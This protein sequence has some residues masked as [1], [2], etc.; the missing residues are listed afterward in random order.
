MSLL[1]YMTIFLKTQAVQL[2]KELQILLAQQGLEVNDNVIEGKKILIA[3]GGH[4]WT[5]D[6]SGVKEHAITSNEALKL[7]KLPKNISILGSGYIAIE[8]AFI[9][10]GFGSN[11]N[12]IQI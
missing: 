8:F 4:P 10:R 3:T 1:E 11:V 2:L 6:I 7:P 5:P 9:F 12:L